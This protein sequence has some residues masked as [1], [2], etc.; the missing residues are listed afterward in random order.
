VSQNRFQAVA[1]TIPASAGNRTPVIQPVLTELSHIRKGTAC[2][3]LRNEVI[4]TQKC[5]ESKRVLSNAWRWCCHLSLYLY[6]ALSKLYLQNLPSLRGVVPYW[7][8][9]KIQRM[10]PNCRRTTVLLVDTF[11]RLSI[12][13]PAFQLCIPILMFCILLCIVDNQ[14]VRD[15][16]HSYIYISANTNK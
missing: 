16:Q 10:G 13:A 7:H 4:L 6:F 5:Q 15:R 11:A 3:Q 9:L 8:M 14:S 2:I 1:K 12:A